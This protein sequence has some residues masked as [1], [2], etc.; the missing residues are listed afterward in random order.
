M[1][2][3]GNKKQIL[4]LPEQSCCHHCRGLTTEVSGGYFFSVI[5]GPGLT[6]FQLNVRK[7]SEVLLE[8]G[9][10]FI[11]LVNSLRWFSNLIF[12]SK[13]PKRYTATT[14]FTSL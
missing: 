12:V 1:R 4:A 9:F 13:P 14:S 8:I 6:S 2:N 7:Q 10:C 3:Y 11:P 5:G